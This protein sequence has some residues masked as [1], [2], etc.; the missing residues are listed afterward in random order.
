M[1]EYHAPIKKY[2]K[3]NRKIKLKNIIQNSMCCMITNYL[4]KRTKTRGKQKQG[5]HKY[6][7]DVGS[8]CVS[9]Q[10]YKQ[11]KLWLTTFSLM[12][13]NTQPLT[14]DRTCIKRKKKK[15][16]SQTVSDLQNQKLPPSKFYLHL[17]TTSLQESTLEC[18]VLFLSGTLQQSLFPEEKKK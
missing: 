7:N 5:Q 1:V 17:R 3:T 9:Q 14:R 15:A 2:Q 12:S 10:A 6:L 8:L 16:N 18:H 13:I 11:V 4:Y